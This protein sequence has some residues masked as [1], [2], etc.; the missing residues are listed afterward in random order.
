VLSSP[1][2]TSRDTSIENFSQA[3]P[4]E[5][6][7][8]IWQT[9]RAFWEL[10]KP[11]PL[12]MIVYTTVFG[13]LIA[14]I[15]PINIVHLLLTALGVAFAAGG[16]LA[17]NQF[18]E[19][20]LDAKMVRTQG[21]PI[22]SGRLTPFAAAVFGWT[23]MLGGY[24]FLWF[25]INP[26]TSI[27]TMICG[28]SYNY[29][30][31]P[32]KKTSSYSSFVGAIPGGMLPVMGWVA[33][34]GEVEIGAVLLF[35]ILFLWQIPHAL[36]ISLRHQNDYESVGMQQLPIAANDS[37]SRRHIVWN[38]LVLVPVTLLPYAFNMTEEAYLIV[39]TVLGFYLFMVS[40]KYAAKKTE[41]LARTMFISLTA[42]LP[43]LLLALYIDKIAV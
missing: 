20:E 22:P 33:V 7:Q 39:A 30:Y 29:L 26:A 42:Y 15:E 31:T 17:L 8:T 34:R 35:S 4:R 3:N 36:I 25:V 18:D 1:D 32:M 10:T 24:A 27:A 38:I 19:R 11:R 13:Y 14:A 41:A 12:I 9:L 21:R 28:V 5:D 16:S 23:T 43:L 6:S 40:V 37:M 2:S